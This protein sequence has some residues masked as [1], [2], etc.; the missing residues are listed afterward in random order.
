MQQ[1]ERREKSQAM[2][3]DPPNTQTLDV[4]HEQPVLTI[5]MPPTDVFRKGTLNCA[6]LDP[7]K[8]NLP[9]Q[10]PATAQIAATDA[11]EAATDSSN[12]GAGGGQ[13]TAAQMVMDT[14]AAMQL[15]EAAKPANPSLLSTPLETEVASSTVASATAYAPVPLEAKDASATVAPAT[16]YAPVPLEAKDAS[17]TVAPPTSCAPVPLEAK[18]ASSTVAPATLDKPHFCGVLRR[19][20]AVLRITQTEENKDKV[21]RQW[22][23]DCSNEP[24]PLVFDADGKP[25]ANPADAYGAVN[26]IDALKCLGMK[27][28]QAQHY[29]KVEE[30]TK[31]GIDRRDIF[32]IKWDEAPK[33]FFSK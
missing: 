3:L 15:D 6:T 9:I 33:A 19:G 24:K 31:L 23:R 25:L 7:T 17:A 12:G 26:V 27:K 13:G 16:S 18:D 22:T 29:V 28:T 8:E 14:S 21:V 30:L 32:M 1:V 10:L 4:M 2:L 20:Y 5:A 11:V